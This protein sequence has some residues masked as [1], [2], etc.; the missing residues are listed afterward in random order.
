MNKIKKVGVT[1]EELIETDNQGFN[2]DLLSSEESTEVEGGI[3]DYGCF[4]C[5]SNI[6]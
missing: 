5:A 1:S 4:I 3:C 2:E 6:W